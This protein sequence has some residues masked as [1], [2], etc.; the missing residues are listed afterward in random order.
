MTSIRRRQ[1]VSRGAGRSPIVGRRDAGAWPGRR[2]VDPT[3]RPVRAG[4]RG[5]AGQGRRTLAG[6]AA[7]ARPR[8]AVDGD[9]VCANVA[10]PKPATLLDEVIQSVTPDHARRG[11]A[12]GAGADGVAAAAR[13]STPR[14]PPSRGASR[15]RSTSAPTADGQGPAA[16]GRA[17]AG[18]VVRRVRPVPSRD[19]AVVGGR[20]RRER[21]WQP[22]AGRPRVAGRAVAPAPRAARHAEPDRAAGRGVR[23]ARRGSQPEPGAGAT[24]RLR[25]QPAVPRPAAG[26]R[27]ARRAP[28][29]PPVAAPRLPCAVG[30]RRAVHRP[31]GAAGTTSR[32][33]SCPTRCWARCPATSSSCSSC[34]PATAP[35]ATDVLH[36]P[37]PTPRRPARPAQAGPRR[38][39]RAGPAAA[40]R[41]RRPQRPGPR[42]PRPHPPGRG[43]PRGG[44][45]PARRR[46]DPRAARRPRH[47]P[48]RRDVRPDHRGH[49]RARRRRTTPRTRRPGCGSGSPTA[50][51]GR[52]TPCFGVPR[53][54]A[55]ARHGPDHRRRRCSTS[56]ARPAVR[57][58]FGFDDD[59]LERLRDW[60]ARGRRALGPR[61]RA[62]RARWQLGGVEQGTWRDGLD[63]LLLGVAME[64]VTAIY[65]DVVPLD[66][67]DSCRHRPGRPARR[68]G[69]PARRRAAA[70]CPASTPR[71]SGWSGSRRRR[72]RAG[73]H[74]ARHR[75][76]GAAAARR[77]RAT[78]PTT[79][80]DSTAPLDLAGRP[81]AAR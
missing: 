41:T 30:H 54:A 78:S 73:R 55:R 4:H 1:K 74:G 24:V 77:A 31:L 20:R 6:A 19:A 65:G 67:V 16:R 8:R 71:P 18:A 3:R 7:V 76:A 47:V 40:A 35:D 43:A 62:P 23:R 56:R 63:R 57:R 9:G 17:S 11:R 38:R 27:R 72:A 59:E 5:R 26:A 69:R 48:R 36:A 46:P 79:A 28:R 25:C 53:P 58:R 42:L 64:G 10:F 33:A 80:A 51:C 75:L 21:R 50:R 39:P 44:R 68:A 52:P 70:R 45:R 32:G 61:R 49:V 60:T 14:S 12:M 15:S 66:D 34:L 2:A 37:P 81:R 29:R 13:S 22:A